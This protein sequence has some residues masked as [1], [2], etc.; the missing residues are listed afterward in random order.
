[1]SAPSRSVA[2]AA[3]NDTGGG[4]RY[5]GLGRSD[6]QAIQS[7]V[8][9][10]DIEE[11]FAAIPAAARFEGLLELEAPMSEVEIIDHLEGLAAANASDRRV[12]S[13]LGA[14]CNPHFIPSHV[15]ALIQR[16]EFLTAYTPYQPEVGQGTL[17]AIF[18]FQSL[19][20]MLTGMD[21]CN[22]SVYDGASS[23]A[24]AVLM[25]RR[26]V[27][28]GGRVLLSEGLHPAYEAVVRTY[29][30]FIDDIQFDIMP[31]DGN[32]RTVVDQLGGD[33]IALVLQQ[34]N[35]LGVVE[36]LQ[37]AGDQAAAID[38]KFVVNTT[39]PLV[40]GL[41]IPPAQ[42]GADLVCGELQSFG[43]GLNFGGP[44]VGFMACLDG[45][46]RNLPGRLV[47]RT[48]DEEGKEGYVLTLS[49]REQH[50]RRARATSNI[51][52]NEALCALASCIHMCSLGG[53]GIAHL[54]RTNLAKAAYAVKALAAHGIQAVYEAPHFNEFVV[55]VGSD[56]A[57]ILDRC[58]AH[59]VIP[60]VALGRFDAARADQL[61]ICVT[62]VHTK[63]AIDRMANVLAEAVI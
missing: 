43:N 58:L 31:L 46:K 37:A 42:A 5:L 48:I 22:A 19:V 45:D 20:C 53:K 14:G 23:V 17:Q 35:F 51:C 44:L 54:A 6:R 27:R 57:E 59:D 3:Y 1:M 52:T 40:F 25:V 61:L 8:G 13:F 11:L 15:D 63:G 2:G 7:T 36:D 56:S 62:E 26:L 24:E 10:T 28:R 60:G 33:V 30:R 50:I 49:A 18:E 47:G 12:L 32:G 21:V 34:P 39:E 41:A 55:R 16:Q 4:G 38:A 29:A 9:I